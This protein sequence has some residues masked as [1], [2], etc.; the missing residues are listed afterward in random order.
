[1][2]GQNTRI[3]YFLHGE[4]FITMKNNNYVN[5]VQTIQNIINLLVLLSYKNSLIDHFISCVVL[6]AS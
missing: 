5:Y 1:M 4:Q 3:P 6:N 2:G